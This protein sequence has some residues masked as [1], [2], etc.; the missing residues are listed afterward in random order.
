MKA[1]SLFVVGLIAASSSGCFV[2][3]FIAKS[4]PGSGVT[5]TVT[6]EMEQF[7]SIEFAGSG[8]VTVTCGQKPT[9]ALTTDDNLVIYY[10]TKVENGVLKIWPEQNVRPTI[11]PT[12]TISTGQLKEIEVAGSGK[13][14]VEGLDVPKFEYTVAGSGTVIASGNADQLEIEIAGSGKFELGELEAK[15]VSIEIA[16]SGSGTVN[17]DDNLNVEIAGSGRVEYFGSPNV[18]QSIAGSGKVIQ[19]SAESASAVPA[20]ASE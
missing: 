9:L 18:K 15:D 5:A 17:A 7:D 16:G 2:V 10:Q 3:N 1:L 6:R 20:E 13:F 14:N 4:V 19:I 12:F 8:N 11:G